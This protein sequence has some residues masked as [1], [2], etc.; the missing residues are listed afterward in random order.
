MITLLLVFYFYNF[1]FCECLTRSF[2]EKIQVRIFDEADL[3][4][5]VRK[6]LRNFTGSDFPSLPA[7]VQAF[8]TRRDAAVRAGR[9]FRAGQFPLVLQGGEVK[10][11]AQLQL[12]DVALPKGAPLAQVAQGTKFAGISKLK[13]AFPV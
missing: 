1:N 12:D 10:V 13:N 4:K 6:G 8:W 2:K 7:R 11:F 5:F 9:A 3:I